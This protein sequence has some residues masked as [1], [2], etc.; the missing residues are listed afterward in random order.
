MQTVAGQAIAGVLAVGSYFAADVDSAK[1]QI[2]ERESTSFD[3]ER[4]SPSRWENRGTPVTVNMSD[5]GCEARTDSPAQQRRVLAF[6]L[7]A[8]ML[9]VGIGAGLIAGRLGCRPLWPWGAL[10]TL[11]HRIVSRYSPV[12]S[13]S[14]RVLIRSGLSFEAFGFGKAQIP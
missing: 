4:R 7:N 3:D 12:N 5:F 2:P 6:A 10:G 9:S 11:R 8:T 14:C 13:K 1:T